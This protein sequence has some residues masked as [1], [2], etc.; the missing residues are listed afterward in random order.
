MKPLFIPSRERDRITSAGE[1]AA[2]TFGPIDPA[3]PPDDLSA[4]GPWCVA[5]SRGN[6]RRPFLYPIPSKSENDNE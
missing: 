4:A 2:D 3:V 1:K 5:R 6:R